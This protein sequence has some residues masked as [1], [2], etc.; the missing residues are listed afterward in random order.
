[1]RAGCSGCLLVVLLTVAL[2]GGLTGSIWLAV[3]L[4]DDPAI[5]PGTETPEDAARA[6]RKLARALRPDRP[7]QGHPR[8]ADRLVLT[9]AE[10]EAL[11]SRYLPAAAE[12]PLTGIRLEL[13]G[14]DQVEFAGQ[15]PLRA[16]LAELP[17]AA[18]ADLLP[19]RWLEHP[20][21]IRL[22]ARARI[23]IGPTSQRRYLRLD[24]DRFWVGRR[25]LPALLLR[26]ALSPLTLR[27]LQWPLPAS[28]EEVRLETGQVVMRVG[29][30]P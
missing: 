8:R 12:L 5:G 19:L 2:T 28:V 26:V 13:P 14:G 18:G 9:E 4:L 6:G 20:V 24:V 29:L 15:V 17:L 1:V 23:D 3:G 7:L 11:L 10:V 16:V 27:V 30:P 21:W 25:R 22:G